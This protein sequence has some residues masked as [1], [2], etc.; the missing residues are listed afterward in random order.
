MIE[1]L[2]ENPIYLVEHKDFFL[3]VGSRRKYRFLR[4]HE[5]NYL[6]SDLAA[7]FSTLLSFEPSRFPTHFEFEQRHQQLLKRFPHTSPLNLS[8]WQ[9]LAVFGCK[10]GWLVRTRYTLEPHSLVGTRVRVNRLPSPVK[11]APHIFHQTKTR[12]AVRWSGRTP[13]TQIPS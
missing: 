4:Y 7:V 11:K 2:T 9:R 5:T 8:R 10:V 12:R 3:E 6:P 13:G 1:A